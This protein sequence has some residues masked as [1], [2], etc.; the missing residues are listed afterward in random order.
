MVI[1]KRRVA[2][3]KN[4]RFSQPESSSLIN[5]KQQ[6]YGKPCMKKLLI[7]DDNKNFGL[8]LA[9][10]LRRKGFLAEET[11]DAFEAIIK[12]KEGD[13]DI[14]MTDL[15]MPKINGIE[16]ARIATKVDPGLF[17]ILVSAYDFKDF[18]Q[19]YPDIRRYPRI[20][21]PFQ[22]SSL[23]G[24]MEH[25]PNIHIRNEKADMLFS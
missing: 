1:V 19:Q 14:L 5:P 25:M 13:Y 11:T 3:D 20:S 10:G 16:L 7:V 17:I 2:G 4:Q 8:S 12:I 6:L 23:L 18:E 15:R 24:L 9:I 21:K 22:M